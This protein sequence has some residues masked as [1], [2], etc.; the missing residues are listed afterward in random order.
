MRSAFEDLSQSFRLLWRQPAFTLAALTLLALGIGLTSGIFSV[1]N[2][3]L[4]QPLP[5]RE[6]DRIFYA[7]TRGENQA[8]RQRAFSPSEF[9][10]YRSQVNCFSAFSAF[11]HYRATWTR[12]GSAS[13]V[14]TLLH[15]AGYLDVLGIQPALGRGFNADD[16]APGNGHAVIVSHGFWTERMG[17][18]PDVLGK[19]MVLDGESFTLIGVL[20]P[21]QS[22]LTTS[23][24]YVPALF[25]PEE[26]ASRTSRYLYA[27]ARLK[28]GV[29]RQQ[30]QS[31]IDAAAAII[32]QKYPESNK[33]WSAY[34]APA[35]DEI[36]GESKQPILVLFAAV[37]LV[38]VIACANLANLFMV[39]LS[40]RRR[41]IAVR[42][43]LGASQ[44]RIMRG[45][46]FESLWVSLLGG[47][48]GLVVA[49]FCIQAVQTF[50]PAAVPRLQDAR[51]DTAV[52]L[53]ALGMSVLSGLLFGIGP[54]F[55]LLRMNLAGSLRDES[56]SSTGGRQRSRSRNA[57]VVA[58]VALSVILLV[59]AG[60]LTRTF[61]R[62]ASLDMG[63][64]P[65]G[66]LTASNTL[67]V[68]KYAAE[69]PRIEYARRALEGLRGI[70]G[71]VAAG[72]GTSIPMQQQN[73]LADISIEGQDQSDARMHSVSY[74]AV[75]PGFLEAIGASI[76]R[77]R[78]F[79]E[80]DS[81]SSAKV[82]LVSQEFERMYLSGSSAVG[83]A[84]RVKVGKHDVRAEIVGVVDN[85][86]QL[87]PDEPPR[88]AVYQPH[89]QNPWPFL[90]FAVKTRGIDAAIPAEMRRVLNA[91][92]PDCPAHRIQPLSNLLSTAVR[93]R[94]LALGLLTLFSVLAVV[95]SL[96]GLYSVLAISVAQRRREMGIRMALGA[97]RG[98]LT[99]M[100]V[101]QGGMLAIAGLVAGFLAAPLASR[102]IESMLIGVTPA[103]P[104]TYTVVAAVVLAASLASSVV[105]AWRGS[106]VN[107]V[108]ALRDA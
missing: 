38:L 100:V 13:K 19:P 60:L 43:A 81:A 26:L 28:T 91:V 8:R 10:E 31:E 37:C 89:S 84:V 72:V 41:D 1:V 95:L 14:A 21:I 32:A 15:T 42:S 88:A 50:S 82:L 57:L 2:A 102:A 46:L 49:H 92:D 83:R 103:D 52:V 12:D 53:A 25:S 99:A 44:M 3:V 87:R 67:P 98:N 18:N 75:S 34:L 90:A 94:R 62:L 5:F 33:G 29:S 108:D 63:F 106:N 16:F 9:L 58:E 20:P 97:T 80:L 105:P 17:R 79:N 48:A 68:P 93:E 24:V 73:W 65:E 56:R 54:A 23:E 64:R 101:R 45:L 40:A 47:C 30:A 4:L 70:P 22:E 27:I 107:P 39:R 96:V 71:V 55:S 59:C 36:I 61:Q 11:R 74:H 35:K 76:K 86:R 6:P 69:A 7:W 85:V 78:A 51:L 77:G 66:V 104:A